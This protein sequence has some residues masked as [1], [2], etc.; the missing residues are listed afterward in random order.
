MPARTEYEPGTFCWPELST[1]DP[2]GAKKFY[3]ELLGWSF[4]DEDVGPDM[5]YSMSLKGDKNI[6]ALYGLNE[7][8]KSQ[9][10]PPHWLS[11]VSVANVDE[12]AKKA[13]SLGATI[14]KEPFDV[15]D[16]GRMAVLQDPSDAVFAI[17]QPIKH[18][19]AELVNEHG[20]LTWNELLT[21]DVDRA[22][23]F[24]T[25][26]FGWGSQ[27]TDMGEF[28]YTS[29][30]NGERPAGGMMEINQETMG[31]LPAHW[32]V[33]F[34]VDD[35]DKTAEKAKSLGANVVVAPQDIPEVGRFA[36]MVDPQGAAFSIIK[37][38]NPPT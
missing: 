26:L 32:M 37:L 29:Y 30:M 17:W 18:I 12:T 15:F 31:D 16:A 7:E 9:G 2:A 27:T 25:E 8:M 38:L 21:K 10:I 34:A 13:Q 33:Y 3:G 24:Y 4:H 11:Y 20:T 23:K 36:V 22:G 35:C 5:V 19:G 28:N 1:T 14:I 6:G